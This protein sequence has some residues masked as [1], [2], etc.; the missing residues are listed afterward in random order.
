MLG[1]KASPSSWRGIRD[2]WNSAA[3][4]RGFA[5]SE[6]SR[7]SFLSSLCEDKNVIVLVAHG[8]DE[9]LWFPNPQPEGS[10]VN[11]DDVREI[12]SRIKDNRP[13]VY[14]FS[15]EAAS[16]QKVNNWATVLTEC[17]TEAVVAPQTKIP[18]G[19]TRKLFE[20][21]L[22]LGANQAP[23]T[24]L[25]EAGNKTGQRYLENWVG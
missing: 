3:D 11:L 21:F 13:T 22:E 16:A 18:S 24:A 20:K 8:S 1:P 19:G 17:G 7:A 25:H 15:C 4:K 5:V 6:G 10:K 2:G 12:A 23:I 14:L 9:S